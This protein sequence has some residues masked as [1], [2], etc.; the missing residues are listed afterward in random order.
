MG[1]RS[2]R[3]RLGSRRIHI[4]SRGAIEG[5]PRVFCAGTENETSISGSCEYM[6]RFPKPRARYARFVRRFPRRR[7]ITTSHPKPNTIR[8][9]PMEA[10]Y[11][12]IEDD[13]AKNGAFIPNGSN[14]GISFPLYEAGAS[15]RAALA[16]RS[17]LLRTLHDTWAYLEN[18]VQPGSIKGSVFTLLAA[19]VGAGIL[20]LPYA[21]MQSGLVGAVLLTVICGAFAF[22]SIHLLIISTGVTGHMSYQALAAYCGGPRLLLLTKIA[23]LFNLFGTTGPVPRPG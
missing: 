2:R 19:I 16:A 11:G 8:L 21:F 10:G 23:L 4:G 3:H 5:V 13:S 22:Y 14:G 9:P 7:P 18:K 17:P 1:R 20:A 12:A 15:E 6:I